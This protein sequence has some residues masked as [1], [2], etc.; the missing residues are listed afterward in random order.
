MQPYY[1]LLDILAELVAEATD[2]ANVSLQTWRQTL[3]IWTRVEKSRRSFWAK[4]ATS[5]TRALRDAIHAF[6]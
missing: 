5:W 2:E 4:F 6:S 1:A 3:Q